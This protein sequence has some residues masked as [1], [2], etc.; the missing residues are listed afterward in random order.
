MGDDGGG[1]NGV[2]VILVFVVSMGY[3]V[4]VLFWYKFAK[5]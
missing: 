2:V 5:I 3:C 1:I 4:V